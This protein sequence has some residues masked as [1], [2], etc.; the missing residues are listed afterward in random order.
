MRS[1]LLPPFRRPGGQLEHD[2]A[3][4]AP[5]TFLPPAMCD[6]QQATVS[7]LTTKVSA[8]ASSC[9]GA[10]QPKRPS[11]G[12]IVPLEVAAGDRVVLTVS[13]LSNPA[14]RGRRVCPHDVL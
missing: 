11:F 14:T 2:N 12:V 7:D 8:T 3:T 5:G 6:Q 1:G 10:T 9:F 4:A 13:G